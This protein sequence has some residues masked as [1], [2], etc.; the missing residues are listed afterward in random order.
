[1][2][3]ELGDWREPTSIYNDSLS[4]NVVISVVTN[5]CPDAVP[6]VN[7][8]FRTCSTCFSLMISTFLKILSAKTLHPRGSSFRLPP[9]PF[10][11]AS[12]TRAKVPVPSVLSSSK[13]SMRSVGEGLPRRG[14]CGSCAKWATK[15][16]SRAVSL[17]YSWSR[18]RAESRCSILAMASVAGEL[19]G[20]A[21][22]AA[23]RE[24]A[25]GRRAQRWW[26][27]WGW[28]RSWWSWWRWDEGEGGD[29]A[30]VVVMVFTLAAPPWPLMGAG[31]L[32]SRFL[33]AGRMMVRMA[34]TAAMA[35]GAAAAWGP[36]VV[37]LARL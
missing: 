34:V 19:G 21:Q 30:V 24:G 36:A 12:R 14:L 5:G 22:T 29:D 28:S 1:M 32:G 3:F 6:S 11:L 10:N 15:S 33:R 4:T 31:G 17:R 35:K 23:A 27:R 26:W 7:R 20:G 16:N 9:L 25:R 13:S 8:S 18:S 2:H 37:A